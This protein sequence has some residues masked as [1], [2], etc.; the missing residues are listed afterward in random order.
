[1][2]YR[3]IVEGRVSTLDALTAGGGVSR[4]K[5]VELILI[6][7]KNP[8][9]CRARNRTSDLG[10]TSTE[11]LKQVHPGRFSKLLRGKR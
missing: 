4:K 6:K 1:M 3:M 8:D 9:T 11:A 2:S 5:T 7:K 10:P